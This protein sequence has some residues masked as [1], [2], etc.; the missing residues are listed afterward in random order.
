MTPP[1]VV[2]VSPDDLVA[3]IVTAVRDALAA[4]VPTTASPAQLVSRAGLARVLGVS[5]A[6]IARAEHA[7]Q[8]ASVVVGSSRRY[9]VA[10]VRAALEAGSKAAQPTPRAGERPRGGLSGVRLLSRSAK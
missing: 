1:S 8:I 4:Q 2:V 9:D 6:T 10:A 5:V 7:G 3:I